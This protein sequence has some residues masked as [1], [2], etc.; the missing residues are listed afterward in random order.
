M[1][2]FA[3]TRARLR[4]GAPIRWQLVVQPTATVLVIWK[5][6]SMNHGL[7]TKVGIRCLSVAL[8]RQT[9]HAITAVV[10]IT[11]VSVLPELA[12]PI[13]RLRV[14]AVRAQPRMII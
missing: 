10:P 7:I 4:V 13:I 2:R 3:A 14:H 9:A 5:P 11:A 8:Y 12:R 6:W 1:R